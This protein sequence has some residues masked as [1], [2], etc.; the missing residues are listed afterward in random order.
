MWS[1][2]L[3]PDSIPSLVMGTVEI[4]CREGEEINLNVKGQ[5]VHR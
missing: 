5:F 1:K 4:I 2:G 3:W